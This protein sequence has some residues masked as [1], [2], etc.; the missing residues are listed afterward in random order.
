MS[1]PTSLMRQYLEAVSV[2]DFD[3]MRQ[4]FHPQYSYTSG[5]GQRQEGA[6]AGIAVAKMFTGAFPDLK[7][8]VKHMHPAGSDVVVTEFTV[9]ATHE[10]E[11]MGIAP[12]GRKV[13]LP[14]CN[15]MEVRDGKIYAEREYFDITHLM[16]QLGIAAGSSHR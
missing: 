7:L 1:D 15:V 12:T 8:D 3:R 10:G 2:R 11:L 13:E 9:R 6:D 4:L 5:N 14:V 16:Q